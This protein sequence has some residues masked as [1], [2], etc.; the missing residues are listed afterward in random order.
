MLSFNDRHF[1]KN[2]SFISMKCSSHN[3]LTRIFSAKKHQTMTLGTWLMKKCMLQRRSKFH[4]LVLAVV[5]LGSNIDTVECHYSWYF[6]LSFCWVVAVIFDYVSL[7]L[8]LYCSD[9]TYLDISFLKKKT[10]KIIFASSLLHT[11]NFYSS[12]IVADAASRIEVIFS[13]NELVRC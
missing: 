7:C 10:R 6:T 11:N 8:L 13:Y 3:H 9:F 4:L 5:F 1:V 12:Q 2:Q